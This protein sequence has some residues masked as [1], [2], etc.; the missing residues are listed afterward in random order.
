MLFPC[1]F[2]S[3]FFLFLFLSYIMCIILPSCH[4]INILYVH[5][6]SV[7]SVADHMWFFIFS[8]FFLS[9]LICAFCH[10]CTLTLLN[11]Q[12]LYASILSDFCISSTSNTS[13]IHITHY[14]ERI[15]LFPT[16]ITAPWTFS[17]HSNSGY[18]AFEILSF[19]NLITLVTKAVNN[20]WGLLW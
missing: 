11:Q 10:S 2:L 12:S 13:I 16:E 7:F 20:F 19:T 5:R 4:P 18:N 6:S 1:I 8:V 15:S 3:F 9:Q 14:L 17:A